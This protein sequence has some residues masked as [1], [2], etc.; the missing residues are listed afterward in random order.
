MLAHGLEGEQA[1][2]R[3]D[4]AVE[5][6]D[7]DVTIE[8]VTGDAEQQEGLEVAQPLQAIE[9]DGPATQVQLTS[10]LQHIVIH[11]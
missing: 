6:G 5:N 9:P 3:E 4:A 7:N 11:W 1:G 2:Q 8:D 10:I